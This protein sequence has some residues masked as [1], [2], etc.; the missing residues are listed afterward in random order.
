MV[1][2]VGLFAAFQ[3]LDEGWP[4]DQS[5]GVRL[6]AALVSCAERLDLNFTPVGEREPAR[7]V[8]ISLSQPVPQIV[9]QQV[10]LPNGDYIIALELTCGSKSGPSA[11]KK[12]KTSRPR[13][14]SLSGEETLV[15]FDAETPE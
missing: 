9:R 11:P 10:H 1:L 12:S 15:V 14:V 2:G 6:P 8:S 5:I 7:G 3:W 13:R 4:R